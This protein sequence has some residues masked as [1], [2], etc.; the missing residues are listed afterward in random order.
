MLREPNWVSR[1]RWKISTSIL[2]GSLWLSG[3]TNTEKE[4]V[5][6]ECETD[7][8]DPDSDTPETDTEESDTEEPDTEESDTVPTDLPDTDDTDDTDDTEDSEILP[9]TD[10]FVLI[11][12]SETDTDGTDVPIETD[13]TDT[14]TDTDTDGTDVP[15]RPDDV[16]LFGEGD[17]VITEFQARPA[18]PGCDASGEYIEILN[19]TASPIW[20]DHMILRLGSAAWTVS[21]QTV[22]QPGEYAVGQ[23]QL[24]GVP[25]PLGFTPDFVF[26]GRLPNLGGVLSIEN[27]S[28]VFDTVDYTG[29]GWDP[30][31]GHSKQLLA[32]SEDSVSN[33]DPANW[34]DADTPITGTDDFGTPGVQAGPCYIPPVD[35]DTD[36]GADTDTDTDTEPPGSTDTFI[37]TDLD[38]DVDDGIIGPDELGPGDLRIME[39]M[40]LPALCNQQ[41]FGRYFEVYNTASQPVSLDGLRFDWGTTGGTPNILISYDASSGADGLVAPG[42]SAVIQRRV[43]STQPDCYDYAA[44]FTFT[45]D[46]TS[47]GQRLRLHNGVQTI[48]QVD[49]ALFTVP[50]GRA[51]GFDA[52]LYATPDLNVD[53]NNWCAQRSEIPPNTDRGTPNEVNDECLPP[54]TGDTDESDPPFDTDGTDLPSQPRD[55]SDGLDA[56]ELLP[57]ELLITEVMAD[58][59]DCRTISTQYIE[60]YNASQFPILLDGLLVETPR[61]SGRLVGPETT[62]VV[63]DPGD[64]QIIARRSTA[65]GYCYGFGRD[66]VMSASEFGYGIFRLYN[67]W[68]E[69]DAIDLTGFSGPPGSAAQ[70][71]PVVGLSLGSNDNV[72]NWCASNPFIGTSTVDRGTPLSPNVCAVFTGDTDDTADTD[73]T[74]PGVG[75]IDPSDG[76]QVDELRPSD[77]ILTEI[78]FE[79]IDCSRSATTVYVEIYNNTAYDVDLTDVL[80]DVPGG[81]GRRIDIVG[82]SPLL[83]PSGGYEAVRRSVSFLPCY[84]SFPDNFEV[85]LPTLVAGTYTLRAGTFVLDSVDLTGVTVPIGDSL[86]LDPSVVLTGDVSNDDPA[87]WCSGG[88]TIEPGGTDRGTPSAANDCSG[89]SG[90]D[91]DTDTADTDGGPFIPDLFTEN[92]RSGDLIIT[93]LMEASGCNGQ[94]KGEYFEAFNSTG[95][96]IDLTGLEIDINGFTHSVTSLIVMPGQYIVFGRNDNNRCYDREPDYL[97]PGSND[98][99]LD[100]N[101]NIILL[102]VPASLGGP[103]TIDVV[104]TLNNPLWGEPIR[105]RARELDANVLD[106]NENNDPTNWCD[107]PNL[108][109]F[110]LATSDDFI[111]DVGTP[112]TS[113]NPCVSD[114]GL[115]ID[116]FVETFIVPTSTFRPIE[117]V[118]PGDI[119]ITEFMVAPMDCSSEAEAEYIEVY[120]NTAIP[121]DLDGVYIED[122]DSSV[123]WSILAPIPPF[124]YG[125]IANSA[126]GASS[127]YDDLEPVITYQADPFDNIGDFIRLRKDDGTVLDEVDFRDW[128]LTLGRSWELDP[129]QIDATANDDVANWCLAR[130]RIPG[131]S[132]DKG[133][134]NNVN[135]GCVVDTDPPNTVDV[136]DL[137]P[138]DLVI[139]EV[140]VDSREPGCTDANAEYFEI[141]NTTGSVVNLEGLVITN[142]TEGVLE[143]QISQDILVDIG[144]FATLARFENPRCYGFTPTA[145]YPVLS[146]LSSGDLVRISNSTVVIDEVDFRSGWPAAPRGAAW[147]LSEPL[148]TATSNDDYESWCASLTPIAGASVDRGSPGVANGRCFS[149]TGLVVVIDTDDTDVVVD[150]EESGLFVDTDSDLPT[151]SGTPASSLLAG[152]LVLTELMVDP[153]D[154]LDAE[155]EYIE[156]FNASGDEVDL[157]GLVVEIERGDGT[158]DS[159]TVT[160]ARNVLDG[161]YAVGVRAHANRCYGYPAEFGYQ[162]HGMDNAGGIVRL[163]AGST[164][165]DSFD[166]GSVGAI[167]VGASLQLDADAIDASSNDL[168]DNWCASVASIA[169]A[170]VDRGTPGRPNETCFV[171]PV[172]DTDTDG[173]CLETGDPDACIDFIKPLEDV[174]VG[175]LVIT[176]FMVDPRDCDDTRA[177]YIEIYNAS[178]DY[179]DLNG[180]RISNGGITYRVSDT[181]TVLIAPA[182]L[183]MVAREAAFPCYPSVESE[184]SYRAIRLGDPENLIYIANDATILDLVDFASFPSAPGQA[185]GLDPSRFADVAPGGIAE[186][187]YDGGTPAIT[188]YTYDYPHNDVSVWCLQYSKILG[189]TGDRGTPGELNDPVCLAPGDRPPYPANYIA[190]VD[191]LY[192]GDL[193][194]TEFMP[195]PNDCVDLQAEYIEIRNSTTWRVSLAGMQVES[196]GQA[197]PVSSNYV[198]AP[199]E[200]ALGRRLNYNPAT[201]YRGL[202]AQFEFATSLSDNNGFIALRSNHTVLDAVDYDGWTIPPGIGLQLDPDGGHD[203]ESNDVESAWCRADAV[204]QGGTTDLGTPGQPNVCAVGPGDGDVIIIDDL[205][206]GDLIITEFLATNLECVG[207]PDNE[208]IEI[209]NNTA[210]IVDLNG[211]TLFSSVLG[212]TVINETILVGP[213]EIIVGGNNAQ[214]SCTVFGR[215][216]IYNLTLSAGSDVRLMVGSLIIDAV[217]YSTWTN[218]DGHAWQ[219][220]PGNEDA[221]LNDDEANWCASSIGIIPGTRPGGTPAE[222]NNCAA[223]TGSPDTDTDTDTDVFVDSDTGPEPITRL[224]AIM[225]GVARVAPGALYDGEQVRQVFTEVL[226]DTSDPTPLCV[227][228]WDQRGVALAN[229]TASCPS[230]NFAFETTLTNGIDQKQQRGLGPSSCGT[231]FNAYGGTVRNIAGRRTVAFSPTY[232]AMLYAIGGAPLSVFTYNANFAP[233]QP[234]QTV[235]FDWREE[236]FVQYYYY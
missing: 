27:A 146:L 58:P 4:C 21:T 127:C 172:I 108:P 122:S 57:G 154:C 153:F 204:V 205:A 63:L 157:N 51:V 194:I 110:D 113:N 77:L 116:S 6:L 234:G 70:L 176:E 170:V 66:Y 168:A 44:E 200:T 60:V 19:T 20:L 22:V 101:G 165:I 179:I 50:N 187:P 103:R 140:M 47:N 160:G 161:D 158:I 233:L 26:Q 235:N 5:G 213:G 229:V 59:Q 133:S 177:E 24:L 7:E 227:W 112:G 53:P 34:C 223:D 69:I 89:S 78:Q 216:F 202:N 159:W 188:T 171:E 147:E 31:S 232:G 49:F 106:A 129:A 228:S 111:N 220:R 219:L 130:D 104:D 75:G 199:G 173:G 150:P 11:D 195:A 38:T 109:T 35:T 17:L 15:I 107:T 55:P 61:Q 145:Y 206:P 74:D 138:G 164:V 222:P 46:L 215:S 16:D 163:K 217:D 185:W 52:N 114:T 209:L 183:L 94:R 169:G 137:L 211:L 139:T 76:L 105:G 32:G 225:D 65:F 87:D 212:A 102:R 175:E 14:D 72:A 43:P 115:G 118:Q 201:C 197:F 54:D 79:G 181:S 91:S 196:G 92:L 135:T 178:S 13:E 166:Y 134:P 12:T 42:E 97:Y 33:D 100:D 3:C 126:Q 23:R 131:A 8:S 148:T 231:Y 190:H 68:G 39:L 208:Y 95:S 224:F 82:A 180:L 121:I 184:F 71:D 45:N 96:S 73:D 182:Q 2:L 151:G 191:E 128:P 86:Q 28:E 162:T 81:T 136:E 83:V 214:S 125:I 37:A 132:R 141:Y 192:P 123:A 1:M 155:A 98:F 210:E 9:D 189:T 120:N 186:L 84:S 207:Y 218:P 142:R 85:G 193:L 152:D 174:G 117:T 48:D 29:G 230:C 198:L 30:L 25:C 143:Y 18:T 226:G 203:A 149:E 90:G 36:T 144:T 67:S 56:E 119:V 99:A 221:I 236:I 64:Y 156:V 40:L 167:P 62:P 124:S 88:P 10:S 80:V 93:E 41:R